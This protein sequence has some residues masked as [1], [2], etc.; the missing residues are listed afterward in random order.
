MSSL[1]AGPGKLYS[2]MLPS[3]AR[4]L[5]TWQHES[6]TQAETYNRGLSWSLLAHGGGNPGDKGPQSLLLCSVRT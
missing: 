6:H 2:E 4:T 1:L 5:T 3:V